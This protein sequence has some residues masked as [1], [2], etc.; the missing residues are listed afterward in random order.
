MSRYPRYFL[1]I[2]IVIFFF[3]LNS[4]TQTIVSELNGIHLG[5]FR[6]VTHKTFGEPDD[7]QKV[8]ESVF[9]VYFLTEEPSLYLVFQYH[10]NEPEIIHS[11]QFSG[12]DRSYDPGFRG[13]KLG[14]AASDVE[15]VL[16]KPSKRIAAGE[17]RIRWEFDRSNLSIE[18]G[19]DNK[20]SSIR[21]VDERIEG[22]EP[23]VKA[24][25]NFDEV[26]K[27]L[28]KG[29]NS[30]IAEILSP[31]VEVY[32]GEMTVS[33][34]AKMKNE[35]A[36]DTSGVFA[37]LRKLAKELSAVDRSQ[38]GSY[39]EFLRLRY[40]K[41]S[42]HVIKLFKLTSIKEIVF[43]WT[44][45]RWVIWE[46]GAR[47]EG[48]N[49]SWMDRYSPGSLKDLAGDK[50]NALLNDPNVLM[51][52]PDGKPFAAFSYNSFPTRTNVTFTGASR[53][54]SDST[55]A[56]LEI[57]LTTIGRS[58]D[59]AKLFTTEYHFIENGVDHWLPVQSTL[60]DDFAKEIT[61]GEVVTIFVAW[62]GIKYNSG[63]PESLTV[64]N[65]FSKIGP[66]ETPSN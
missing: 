49:T 66:P 14:A 18:L 26:R 59:E 7:V 61:K 47:V 55:L 58:K 45:R 40:G 16:G 3:A 62:A 11:I 8:G 54:T 20:L 41:D 38:A 42:L 60:I 48:S 63:K 57:W 28:Q 46:I 29:S 15:K 13:L 22:L 25:P 24:L 50:L 35:L 1:A 21:I 12:Q 19:S 33:F 10:P 64:V 56:V 51:T 37:T 52:G 43:M 65:E 4:H 23:D 34:G 2:P 44:G 39:E 6:S 30:E 32:D 31:S 53:K 9:E 17:G 27:I 36:A 5:Q